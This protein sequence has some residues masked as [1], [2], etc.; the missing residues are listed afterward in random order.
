M[1]RPKKDKVLFIKI[2]AVS[3]KRIMRASARL[4][5][6]ASQIAREAV[7]E[8]LEEIEKKFESSEEQRAA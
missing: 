4:D 1:K 2:D 8:K 3:H 7:I 5:R 6:S